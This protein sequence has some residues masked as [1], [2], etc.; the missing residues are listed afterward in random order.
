[1]LFFVLYSIH[2]FFSLFFFSRCLQYNNMR[3]GVGRNGTNTGGAA[4]RDGT[5][6]QACKKKRCLE[7]QGEEGSE[8]KQ[9][10]QTSGQPEG[11]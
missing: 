1:M 9:G 6:G 5:G 2:F 11:T 3:G 7:G 10:T 4:T 8:S